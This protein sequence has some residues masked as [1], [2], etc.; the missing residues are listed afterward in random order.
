[1]SDDRYIPVPI[2]C[3]LWGR[4]AGRCE[5]SGCNKPVSFHA[6]TKETANL[7]QAAHIIGFSPDGPRGENDL[8]EPLSKDITN[9]MLLCGECHKTIDTNKAS[10]PVDLLRQMKLAHEQRIDRVAGIAPNKQSHILL[11]GANVGEHASPLTYPLA[12]SAIMPEWYPAE[13][14]PI[15]LGMVNSSFRDRDGEFW[16]IE[17]AQL[18]NMVSQRI[19]PRL[20]T[21]EIKHLSV[22][23]FAPQP[24]ATLLGFLLSDIP[25]AETYQ[26]H[27]EPPDW[28][29]QANPTAFQYIVTE[30]A[31]T[32]HAPALVLALSATITDDRITS[33]LKDGATVWRVTIPTPNNDYLKSRTQLRQFRETIR[34]L[35][36]RI[37]ARHGH[38]ACLHV[39]P[40]VPLAIAVELGRVLMPKADLPLRI[41]DENRNLGGFV[42]AIDIGTEIPC[43]EDT[44]E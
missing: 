2:R 25:S 16:Q 28:R 23:A 33:V 26:L 30:P 40:A 7:A 31:D 8:S 17:S 44:H 29:W 42:H 32:S 36:D 9:L 10:Y 27:R 37:K 18:R 20:A 6:Q 39:F 35:L 19:R 21:G 34:P 1:M 24:L 3:M 12:A 43:Q 38:G 4:A 14:A 11:Y 41:Y 15:A 22:F 5:F 13:N